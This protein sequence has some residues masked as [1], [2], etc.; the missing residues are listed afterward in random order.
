VATCDITH[1][2]AVHVVTFRGDATYSDLVDLLERLDAIAVEQPPT[3]ILIDETGLKA[4]LIS[5]TD[6]RRIASAWGRAEALKRARI[7]VV[8]PSSVVY[9]LNRMVTIF[10][11]ADG[12]I[13][14]FRERSE[15][16]SWLARPFDE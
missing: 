12:R 15:A 16:T 4:G 9:G 1:Q 8:A 3:R 2:D 11:R 5:T 10:A 13:G 6:L 14:I 7:G